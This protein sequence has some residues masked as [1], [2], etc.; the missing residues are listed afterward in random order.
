M[1]EPFYDIVLNLDKLNHIHRELP[2]DSWAVVG[3]TVNTWGSSS[4]INVSFNIK[5]A[6]LLGIPRK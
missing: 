4:P 1:D 2:P 5:W 3:Y 6:M